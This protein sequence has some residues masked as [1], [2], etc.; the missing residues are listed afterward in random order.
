[1]WEQQGRGHKGLGCKQEIH[2]FMEQISI[3][4]H[5]VGCRRAR[6]CRALREHGAWPEDQALP[7]V[8]R[9]QGVDSPDAHP[10]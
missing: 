6:G 1:M 2:S 10:Y 4:G 7:R 5:C 8:P 9:E 3:E